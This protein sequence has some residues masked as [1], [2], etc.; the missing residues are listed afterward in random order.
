MQPWEVQVSVKRIHQSALSMHQMEE[1]QAQLCLKELG[2]S[3]PEEILV[4]V[5]Y[6]CLSFGSRITLHPSPCVAVPG[7]SSANGP[8]GNWKTPDHC[9]AEGAIWHFKTLAHPNLF[10]SIFSNFLF[11][12]A[13]HSLG[14]GSMWQMTVPSLV[15]V[16]F[17]HKLGMCDWT[18]RNPEVPHLLW[19]QHAQG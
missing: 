15:T 13:I 7:Y 2:T 5:T 14:A 16:P 10:T 3:G 18:M 12:R 17:S 6:L 1:N 8:E 19:L 4:S 9:A 11:S